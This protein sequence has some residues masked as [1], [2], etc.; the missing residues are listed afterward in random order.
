[1]KKF[2][3]F[4][5]CQALEH[6]DDNVALAA[7]DCGTLPTM[8]DVGCWDGEKT[9]EVMDA[10]RATTRLG[11]ELV[12]EE[13]LKANAKG[14]ATAA[15]SA[16]RQRWPYEDASIDCVTSNQVIEHL[17]DVDFFLEEASRV[18]RPGGYLIT[19]TNNLASWHNIFALLFAWAPFDLTNVSARQ[20]GIGNPFALHKGENIDRGS[21][22]THKCI[23]TAHQ[24]FDWQKLY[25]LEKTRLYTSGFYPFPSTWAKVFPRH[26]AFIVTVTRKP[27]VES[28]HGHAAA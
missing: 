27:L 16:D 17:T 6:N 21:S 12:A 14:I 23:Y 9:T 19:S 11:I 4:L 7:R 15:V 3:H 8:L 5:Y 25:G 24:L 28:A 26:S 13:A 22:W 18:L 20:N 10:G 2:L 1:M